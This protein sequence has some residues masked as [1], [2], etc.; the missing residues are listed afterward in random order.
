LGTA[1]LPTLSSMW[2]KGEHQNMRQ[3]SNYYLRVNLFVAI[4]AS[5]GLYFLAL[6]IV[7]VLFMRGRFSM[8]DAIATASVVRIY[9]LTVIASSVVRVLVPSY[10]AI[11]NT[12][13]PAAI[14]GI[15]LAAHIMIAPVLM[16]MFGLE[17]LMS[18]SLLSAALN[19]I[20]LVVGFRWLI[21][22]LG[23]PRLLKSILLFALPGSALAMAIQVYFPIVNALGIGNFSRLIALAIAILFGMIAYAAVSYAFKLEEFMHSAGT[24]IDRLQRRL[25]K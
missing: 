18:S 19:M 2:A 16:G 4:P 12:W 24:F 1:L 5:L 9:S 15:C 6:P 3:T 23:V 11:K 21:G 8:A 13:A 25:K 10:Y 20:L 7:Q 22:P 17:G 14:S